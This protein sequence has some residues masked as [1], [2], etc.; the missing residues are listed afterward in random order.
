MTLNF[1]LTKRN[2]KK[3]KIPQ[4]L[5]LKFGVNLKIEVSICLHHKHK[6]KKCEDNRTPVKIE[7]INM[8]NPK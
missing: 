8:T 2:I 5:K 7:N 1:N 3:K 4:S 6:E